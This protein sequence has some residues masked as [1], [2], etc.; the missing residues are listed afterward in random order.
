MKKVLFVTNYP[1]PYRV[2]FF[3]MLGESTDLTVIFEE[4]IKEQVHRNKE[5]F[6]NDYSRFRA[7][8]LNSKK[9]GNIQ[10]SF[11]IIK[12]LKNK[13]DIIIVSGYASLT[14]QLCIILLKFMHI[15]FYM[16][17]DGGYS[18]SG[19]GILEYWKKIL[20][21]S[22]TK[23]FS[24]SQ[25]SDQ[26]LK[27]YGAKESR[28]IRY[29]FSSLESSDILE[30]TVSAEEKKII[31]EQLGIVEEKVVLTIG[32]FI[33]RKANEVLIEAAKYYENENIGTYIVGGTP[34]EEYI[35]LVKKLSLKNIHF[36]DFKRKDDLKLYYKS[37]DVF[38]MPTRED[39]WGLVINEAL[40]NGLPV[41]ATEKC[42]AAV[43]LIKEEKNGFLVAVDSPREM[44][45]KIRKL[46][47]DTY[48]C[49]KMGKEGLDRIKQYTIEEMVRVHLEAFNIEKE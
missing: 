5:W 32:Q 41:V 12:W 48:E 28:I 16:E 21:S 20:I 35:Q 31:R 45:E 11:E 38:A 47:S 33:P 30:K 46:L 13:Y 15:P 22:A 49:K 3:N 8:F 17:I 19:K 6:D 2:K 14:T 9:L 7:V 10:I 43:E 18:K 29:P 1:A 4:S 44:G 36:V 27:F 34:T 40:A 39:I 25:F 42:I 26:Y 37:A 24:P 23:W